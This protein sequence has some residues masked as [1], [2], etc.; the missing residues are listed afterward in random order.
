MKRFY[1]SAGLA[2]AVF[3]ALCAFLLRGHL[4]DTPGPT[5]SSSATPDSSDHN[6]LE[7]YFQRVWEAESGQARFH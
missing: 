3:V 1:L 5:G 4:K 2:A 7:D 6:F